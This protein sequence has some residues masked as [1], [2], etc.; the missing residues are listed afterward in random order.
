MRTQL[1]EMLSDV[2]LL[3]KEIN[4]IG[5]AISEKAV[6]RVFQMT[7]DS[8]SNGNVTA[9]IPRDTILH[10]QEI[11]KFEAIRDAKTEEKAVIILGDNGE[12]VVGIIY[13]DFDKYFEMGYVLIKRL[14]PDKFQFPDS[15]VDPD[16][17]KA[18]YKINE[19]VI[20]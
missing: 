15:L 16:C 8:M 6:T 7:D 20:N 9:S 14:N 19:R 12:I 18:I 11:D 1:K 3:K 5:E 13:H 17:I 10:C 2:I 4:S